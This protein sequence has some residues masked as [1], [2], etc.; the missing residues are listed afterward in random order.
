M[1]KI[2]FLIHDLGPGGAEKVLVN[3]VNNLDSDKYDITIMALFGG[4]VNEQFI[5]PHITYKAILPVMFRGNIHVMKLFTP[6][7]L[8]RLFI[9]E[10]YDIEVAYLE[11]IS[12]RII[13]GCM[14]VN[15]KL[16]SWIHIEQKTKRCAA[17][18]FRSFKES[19]ET[20]TAFH[21]V[22]C[23]SETVREDMHALYPMLRDMKVLYNTNETEYIKESG[24]EPVPD[25]NFVSNEFK[26][27]G[28]GKL[29]VNKG[30]IRL[31]K[32]H[33][34]LKNMG[35]PVHT[36][37]LG[38]GPERVK[39][40][41]YLQ[42]NQLKDSVTLLGYQSNPYKYMSK[43]DLFVCTSYAEGFSTATTEALILGI[44]V[45][46]VEVSGMKEMLG[47]H[48]EYGIITSNKTADLYKAIKKLLDHPEILEHYKKQA[49]IRGKYFS[50]EKTVAAVEHMF[51]RL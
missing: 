13:S 44:P 46:T 22:V 15:T 18:A 24:T 31:I 10:H 50:R 19:V 39:I 9:K 42:E 3:L 38:D 32:I 35:Y 1:K 26:I 49:D 2:L 21:E 23:V 25:I 20:Y 34:K 48:N 5:R 8:H 51:E 43:C 37:L 17:Q 30:F 11:G 28:V 4:G 29:M 40:E 14:D 45:C 6:R 36:Y 47:H 27:C 12:A 33:H 7:Q 16:I 41:T